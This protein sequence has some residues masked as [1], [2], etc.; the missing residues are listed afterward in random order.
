MWHTRA[1][2]PVSVFSR[3][4]WHAVLRA[5]LLFSTDPCSLISKR[6]E[7]LWN[8]LASASCV[9]YSRQGKLGYK[10]KGNTP[11]GR[12]LFTRSEQDCVRAIWWLHL[13]L[14]LLW[15]WQTMSRA[16]DV[17][18]VLMM[19]MWGI[20]TFSSL[21]EKILPFACAA[22]EQ[23]SALRVLPATALPEELPR[24][25]HVV[26]YC[27]PFSCFLGPVPIVELL[28][29]DL[30]RG[31]R[32]GAST[33]HTNGQP[34]ASQ[35]GLW[36]AGVWW[37]AVIEIPEPTF[38]S[39][40]YHPGVRDICHGCMLSTCR[41]SLAMTRKQGAGDRTHLRED[42]IYL[43]AFIQILVC[44]LLWVKMRRG[45]PDLFGIPTQSSC[46]TRGV[47]R[48][49]MEEALGGGCGLVTLSCKY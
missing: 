46:T 14:Y 32:R 8:L 29:S 22:C 33:S 10:P 6:E 19:N 4:H 45:T 39:W 1:L 43:D 47:K 11:D 25:C 15:L 23:F 12:S 38:L 16:A 20:Q 31:K 7:P 36:S 9:H 37:L 34:Q 21:F 26:Y 42:N 13:M 30:L 40:C 41:K 18:Q 28:L 2:T 17:S 48:N 3:K 27:F 44:S 35:I 49:V 24:F 5:G